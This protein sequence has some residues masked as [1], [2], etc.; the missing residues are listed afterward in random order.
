MATKK[1]KGQDYEEEYASV[2]VCYGCQEEI[3]F[4][5]SSVRYN[6]DGTVHLCTDEDKELFRQYCVPIHELV[7]Y[8]RAALIQ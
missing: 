6:L 4:K 3:T 8:L 1:R 2:Y 5:V 7:C